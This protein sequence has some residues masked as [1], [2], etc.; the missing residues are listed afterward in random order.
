MWLT[1][2]EPIRGEDIYGHSIADGKLGLNPTKYVPPHLRNQ[3][4]SK[5]R[6]E[7]LITIKR[8]LNNALNRLSEDALIFR[9][10]ICEQA[11]PRLSY[12]RRQ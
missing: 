4:D 5:D 8:L 3:D 7:K 2:I 6:Q 10:T 1:P 12:I 11:L 9:G